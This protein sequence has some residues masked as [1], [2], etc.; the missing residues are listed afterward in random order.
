[1]I[2]YI[3][4]T[5]FYSLGDNGFGPEGVRVLVDALRKNTTIT[6]LE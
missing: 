1:M 4:L 3:V 6:T 2:L 5:V